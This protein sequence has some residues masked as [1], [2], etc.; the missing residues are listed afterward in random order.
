[1]SIR[2]IVS[3]FKKTKI[4]RQSRVILKENSPTSA[5]LRYLVCNKGLKGLLFIRPI[6][7]ANLF[8]I[9]FGKILADLRKFL[10]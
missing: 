2:E 6:C 3:E 10:P 4:T 9:S 5:P 8:R 1:M 7:Y